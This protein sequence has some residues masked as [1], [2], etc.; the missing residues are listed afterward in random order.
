MSKAPASIPSRPYVSVSPLS[1]S[2]AVTGLPTSCPAPVFS[3]RVRVVLAPSLKVGAL[4][5]CGWV[6]RTGTMAPSDQR[7][8]TLND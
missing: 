8:V 6:I 7:N 4:F 3:T 2:V 1:L 5:V